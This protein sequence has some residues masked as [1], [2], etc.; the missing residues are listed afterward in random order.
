MIRLTHKYPFVEWGILVSAKTQ[1]TRFPSD[2]WL[3]SLMTVRDDI[4]EMKLSCHVCGQWVREIC[5][6]GR[7]DPRLEELWAMFQR[8]QLNFHAIVHK[9]NAAAFVK[10]LSC[11][12]KQFIF[13]LDDVNNLILEIAKEGGI[14]AVPLFDTSGGLGVLP[15]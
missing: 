12:N 11:P 5:F 1:V 7:L 15:R 6:N 2:D 14:D 4:P 3:D 13:Q 8:V 10:V 9:V